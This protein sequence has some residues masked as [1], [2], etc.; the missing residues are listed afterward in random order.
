[1]NLNRMAERTSGG[2]QQAI[3]WLYGFLLGGSLLVCLFLSHINF[4][5]KYLTTQFLPPLML[6]AFGVLFVF[7]SYQYCVLLSKLEPGK[8]ILLAATVLIFFL[9]VFAASQYWFRTAWDVPSVNNTALAIAH[10]DDPTKLRWYFSQYPN[11]LMLIR[12]FSVFY[13]I[14]HALGLHEQEY[15]VL[16]CIQCLLN[17]LTGLLLA[18][19]VHKLF[20]NRGIVVLGYSL[21]VFLLGISPW[22]S[23]PYSDSTGLP[24]PLI[25][26]AIYVNREK[27]RF[28]WLPWLGMAVIAVIGCHIKP[29]IVIAF[30][31]VLIAGALRW[32]RDGFSR[33]NLLR[34]AAGGCAVIVGLSCSFVLCRAAINS[35]DFRVNKNSAFGAPHFFMMGLNTETMGAYNGGDNLYSSSFP[36]VAERNRGDM[37][38]ALRRIK[39][40]GPV[41]LAKQMVRK[42][43]TNYYDGTFAW[44]GEG[45]FFSGMN[46]PKDNPFCDFFR[47][48]Y[49]G[50]DCV[51]PGRFYPLWLNFAHM[52]WLTVLLL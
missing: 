48:V 44:G 21:Y 32:L 50:E 39:E 9:Q 27:F 1:M 46:E 42:T 26:T 3:A 6:L 49:Y 25:I 12:V 10:G 43:L 16:I 5:R 14:A 47:G 7:G 13:R 30:I 36:T 15:F 28:S 38:L 11:N 45:Q 4:S 23:V 20:E 41:G 34:L 33:K 51:Q 35:M 2:L 22:V 8:W 17:S 37:E 19:V 18:Q 52:V 29:Q 40:M 24:L 31:A